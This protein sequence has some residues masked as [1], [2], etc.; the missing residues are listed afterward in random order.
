MLV[1]FV[2]IF[3]AYQLF[4]ELGGA[5]SMRNDSN[6]DNGA[7]VDYFDHKGDGTGEE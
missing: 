3:F 6:T 7:N 4:V 5:W 2:A 1:Q